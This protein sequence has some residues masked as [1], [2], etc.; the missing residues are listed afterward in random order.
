MEKIA[1][2]SVVKPQGIKGELKV[3]ILANSLASVKN[4][5]VLYDE[6]GRE[7]NVKGIKDAFNGFA[8]LSLNEI[9]TRN[10]SELF[11][12][13]TFYAEKSSISKGK[14]EFFIA[15]IIG[16]KVVTEEGEFGVIKD[17][18]QAN[19][20]MFVVELKGGKTAY[21]PFLKSLNIKIDFNKKEL[22]VSKEKLDGVLYNE[23]WYF[24]VISWNVFTASRKYFR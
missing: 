9:V 6:N 4:V 5:K 17:L 24:I 19:V 15:D 21:F 8:F 13:V 2:F 7:Y 12:G 18:I 3:R 11:R 14:N 23:D 1:C 10:D 22:F 20:D 16:L